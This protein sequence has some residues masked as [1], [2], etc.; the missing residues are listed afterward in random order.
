[1]ISRLCE[2]EHLAIIILVLLVALLVVGSGKGLASIIVPFFKKVFGSGGTEVNLNLGGDVGKKFKE[3][4]QCGLM[5][6]PAK[7]ILHASEHE[8]SIRNEQAIA[9]LRGDLKATRTQLFGKLEGIETVLTEIKIAVAKLVVE[10]NY[11]MGQR[12]K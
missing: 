2:P 8:R 6:D 1:M 10:R 7:C 11:Q 4:E 9:E 3:C 5:V 12:K